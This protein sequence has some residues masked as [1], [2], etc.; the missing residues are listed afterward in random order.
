MTEIGESVVDSTID[1]ADKSQEAKVEK[2]EAA[3]ESKKIENKNNEDG[4]IESSETKAEDSFDREALK[5]ETGWSN[6]I[7]DN[8]GSQEEADIYKNLYMDGTLQETE[9]DGKTCLIRT[10]LDLEQLDDK[11]RTNLERME[12]GL[13]PLDKD[14]KSIE[15]HHIGQKEDSP[16]VELTA[17]EHRGNG[18]DAILHDKTKTTE[19]HGEGNTWDSQRYHYWQERA[20]QEEV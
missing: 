7:I 1:N 16:L 13:A 15:L 10:D 20:E 19:V 5:E 3:D 6:D 9:I 12:A 11:N 14:G 8:I 18:N 2:P 17:D 4:K